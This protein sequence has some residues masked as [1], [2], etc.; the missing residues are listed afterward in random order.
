MIT[1]VRRIP[2]RQF[3]NV[4]VGACTQCL[5]IL[6]WKLFGHKL[7]PSVR[8]GEVGPA[9]VAPVECAEFGNAFRMEELY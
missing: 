8:E 1:D 4:L 5:Q 9:R 6:Q 2:L 7:C 3:H